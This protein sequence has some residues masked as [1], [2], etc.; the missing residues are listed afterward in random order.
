MY[1][2]LNAARIGLNAVTS[3]YNASHGANFAIAV[4]CGIHVAYGQLY[5]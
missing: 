5:L 3:C 4:D 1:S 2:V